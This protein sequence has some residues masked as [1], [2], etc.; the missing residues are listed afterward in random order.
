MFGTCRRPFADTVRAMTR[1]PTL[2]EV[3]CAPNRSSSLAGGAHERRDRLQTTFAA[4]QRGHALAGVQ[5][6]RHGVRRA[7]A[8][9]YRRDSRLSRPAA[10]RWTPRSP[11]T[12][13]PSGSWSRPRT[14][15]A[16]TCSR[17][18]GTRTEPDV[19]AQR[20]RPLAARAAGVDDQAG[21][22]RHHSALLAVLWSVPGCVDGWAELHQSSAKLPLSRDL[23]PAIGYA[24]NG[25]PLARDRERLGAF[26]ATRFG[27]NRLRQVF[28]PGGRA[29]V[30]ARSSAIL[31]SR[32]RCA[33]SRSER[34][35]RILPR[36]RSRR[37]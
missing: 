32:R 18:C 36:V 23:E 3:L 31:R 5:P 13:A 17:S 30:R 26:G 10:A 24:E 29:C 33:R 28:M 35:R 16:A 37:S 12:R 7:A 27:T 8:R 21:T 2:R 11:S 6:A 34:T 9:R 14:A 25:F 22:R 19:R 1:R 15:W 4:R 20:V